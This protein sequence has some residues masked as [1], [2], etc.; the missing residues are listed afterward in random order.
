LVVLFAPGGV[1]RRTAIGP[2]GVRVTLP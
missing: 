2:G 1:A